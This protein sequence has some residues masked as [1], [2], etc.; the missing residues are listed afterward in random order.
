MPSIPFPSLRYL[1]LKAKSLQNRYSYSEPRALLLFK[2]HWRGTL[3]VPDSIKLTDC[4]RVLASAFRCHDWAAL[5]RGVQLLEDIKEQRKSTLSD[6]DLDELVTMMGAHW[7]VCFWARHYVLQA[8]TRGHQAVLRGMK[9]RNAKVR[10]AC[11]EYLDHFVTS[12]DPSTYGVLEETMEDRN[13]NVRASVLHAMG[14]QRCKTD[15]LQDEAVDLFLRGMTDSSQKVRKTALAG[16]HQFRHDPRVVSA[17]QAALHDESVGVRKQ[18]ASGL[19]NYVNERSVRDALL[20]VLATESNPEVVRTTLRSLSIDARRL[21]G[22]T[23]AEVEQRLG[24]AVKTIRQERKPD[25]SFYPIDALSGSTRRG[26]A[27][28]NWVRV[29]YDD[30]NTARSVT[31][32]NALRAP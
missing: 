4:Y 21:V 27:T 32:H 20:D 2:K 23:R 8:E 30:A 5:K 14:C 12:W 3:P 25:A 19:G 18:A 28:G 31:T 16:L 29:L 15:T 1:Q 26:P 7:Q 24:S 9:H 13:A 11:S 22:Q 6:T 10:R 17:H